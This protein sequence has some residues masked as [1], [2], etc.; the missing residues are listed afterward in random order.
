MI[1]RSKPFWICCIL[2]LFYT[3][4]PNL[5]AQLQAKPENLTGNDRAHHGK[6]I[7]PDRFHRGSAA[8]EISGGMWRVDHSFE[9]RLQIKNHIQ[10]AAISATPVLFMADGTEYV[11]PAVNLEPSGVTSLSINMALQ[12]F[13]RK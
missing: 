1:C 12:N 2:L 7:I 9:S 6:K 13:R 3:F 10:L 4:N 11:L 5:S 8:Y